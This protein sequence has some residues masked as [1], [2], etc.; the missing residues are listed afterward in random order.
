MCCLSEVA[1]GAA[2]AAEE[3]EEEET[4]ISGR[5]LSEVAMGASSTTRVGRQPVIENARTAIQR[6]FLSKIFLP[7][8]LL[9]TMAIIPKNCRKIKEKA[10]DRSC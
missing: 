8:T 4:S 1:M 5:C 2:A 6:N 9:D 10:V 3:E 7:A